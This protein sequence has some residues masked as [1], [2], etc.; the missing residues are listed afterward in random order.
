MGRNCKSNGTLIR[1]A[2]ILGIE[3]AITYKYKITAEAETATGP[4]YSCG[5]TPASPAEFETEIV[6]YETVTPRGNVLLE[7]IE[8]FDSLVQNF[9]NEDDKVADDV[10]EDSS[11]DDREYE[12]ED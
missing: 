2:D 9:L 5:G 8:W 11:I 12:R 1:Y 10:G 3:V 7:R 4:T 6:K